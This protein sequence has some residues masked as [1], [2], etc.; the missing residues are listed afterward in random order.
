MP[1]ISPILDVR[2]QTLAYAILGSNFAMNAL[3]DKDAAYLALGQLAPNVRLSPLPA[4]SFSSN[5]I[6]HIVGMCS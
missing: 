6:R 3:I 2:D 4:Q 5:H 1:P